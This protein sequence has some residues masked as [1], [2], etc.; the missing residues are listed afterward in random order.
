MGFPAAY[1]EKKYV[2]RRVAFDRISIIV[3]VVV[4]IFTF[5]ST[6]LFIAFDT[7]FFF[8]AAVCCHR[9]VCQEGPL[10]LSFVEQH[11]GGRHGATDSSSCRHSMQVHLD[12]KRF[13]QKIC[14]PF[15]CACPVEA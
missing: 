8:I 1:G 10:S 13:T 3:V 12:A 15:C 5:H 9:V 2:R 4:H 14:R 11:G 6:T 7:S